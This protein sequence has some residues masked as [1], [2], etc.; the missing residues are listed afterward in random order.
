MSTEVF[1]R[2]LPFAVTDDE[3]RL[4]FAEVGEVVRATVVIDRATGKSR[5]F[6][7]VS[8]S[9]AAEARNAIEMFNGEVVGGRAIGVMPR[10]ESRPW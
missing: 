10:T 4:L 6:G 8:F 7:F 2:N 9:T 3:L 5:G 1:V